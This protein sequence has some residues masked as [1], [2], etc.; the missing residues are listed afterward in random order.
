MPGG[1]L[2]LW[3]QGQPVPAGLTAAQMLLIV[4]GAGVLGFVGQVISRPKP[5][6]GANKPHERPVSPG[7]ANSAHARLFGQTLLNSSFQQESSP[8]LAGK[9]SWVSNLLSACSSRFE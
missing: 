4:L 8:G 2:G 5:E 1:L 3:V 6:P 9:A 7:P